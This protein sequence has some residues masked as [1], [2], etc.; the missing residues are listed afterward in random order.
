MHTERKAI[1]FHWIVKVLTLE[2]CAVVRMYMFIQFVFL[3][4]K[5][6]IQPSLATWILSNDMSKYV[7]IRNF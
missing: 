7:K 1:L 6:H 3:V 2:L 5:I 4:F